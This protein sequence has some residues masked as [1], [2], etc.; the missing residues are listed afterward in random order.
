V[1]GTRV[2]LV[3]SGEALEGVRADPQA[4][5]VSFTPTEVEEES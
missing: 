5:S 3:E 2:Y 4:D 1:E